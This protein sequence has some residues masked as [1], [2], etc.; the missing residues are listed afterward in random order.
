M[1]IDLPWMLGRQGTDHWWMEER[2]ASGERE[3]RGRMVADLQSTT[4]WQ[5]RA[6][7]SQAESPCC[8]PAM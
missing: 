4:M 1:G 6:S 7:N 2:R 3:G 8:P 5:G